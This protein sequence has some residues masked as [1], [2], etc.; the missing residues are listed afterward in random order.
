MFL[1]HIYALSISLG[2]QG[3]SPLLGQGGGFCRNLTLKT[4][5]AAD[6]PDLQW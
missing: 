6:P 5:S 1:S 2:G 4:E 3:E